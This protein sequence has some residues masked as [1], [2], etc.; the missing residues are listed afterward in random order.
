MAKSDKI[1]WHGTV[2]KVEERIARKWVRGTGKDAEF[3][4][5]SQGWYVTFREWP[6]A[7]AFVGHEQPDIATGDK[8]KMSMEVVR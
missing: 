8:V 2:T 1:V 7:A 6:G 4:P 3:V 5:D